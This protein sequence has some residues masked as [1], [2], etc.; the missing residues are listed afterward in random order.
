[1]RKLLCIPIITTA[2][3]VSGI[4]AYAQDPFGGDDDPFG[5]NPFGGGDA[6]AMDP[7]NPFGGGAASSDA[8]GVFGGAGT[9]A[10]DAAATQA[11]PLEVDPDPVVQ[12][13]RA[14]TPKSPAEMAKGLTWLL[15]IRRWDEIGRY[16]DQVAAENWSDQKTAEL[17]RAAG[18]S[19]WIRMRAR[20]SELTDTQKEFVGQIL[21]M[22]S[23]LARDPKWV[24]QWIDR[25]A[26]SDAGERRLAQLRLQDG[27]RLAIQR[28]VERLMSGDPKVLPVMLAGTCLV[29]GEPGI[30]ALRAAN[31]VSDGQRGARVTLA[32]ADLPGKHFTTE[33]AAGLNSSEIPSDDKSR[34][35]EKLVGKFGGLP[36]LDA[37]TK[38]LDREFD[39]R[40]VE[41]FESRARADELTDFVWRLTSD[42]N[43]IEAVD[44]PV[45][46]RSLERL[47][48]V[49]KLRNRQLTAEPLSA[50]NTVALLQHAYQVTPGLDVE[51]QNP[52]FEKLIAEEDRKSPSYWKSTFENA[53][54]WQMHGAAIR[55]LQLMI[56][57]VRADLV[58]MN[59]MSDLLK[60]PRPMVRYTALESIA[61][62]DP[63]IDYRGSERAI[64]TALEMMQL[65][66]GPHALVVGLRSDLRDAAKQQIEAAT[67]SNVTLANSAKSALAALDESNPIELIFLV[68]RVSDQS[69][70]ELIQRIRNTK[71]G[72]SIPIAVLTD[73]LYS[74]ERSLIERTGG[75]VTAVLS[76]NED[77]MQRVVSQLLKELDTEPM[78]ELD[79]A[80]F[81]VVASKFLTHISENHDRY[82]YYSLG[83]YREQLI[84]T[85]NN[86]ADAGRVRLLSGL[87]TRVSQ[88]ELAEIAGTPAVAAADRV[89]A[90]KAFG[91]S[92]QKFGNQLSKSEVEQCYELYNKLGPTDETIV[93]SMGYVLDVIE[94]RS[95]KRAWP[96]GL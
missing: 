37:I 73:E 7:G 53:T 60:D 38:H 91:S 57:N 94:A 44:A 42:G 66:N 29:F 59:F 30:D 84:S 88:F 32:L 74:H 96:Q 65:S 40:L 24:D 5:S 28:L 93:K 89:A 54:K 86:F 50:Q 90:A 56:A 48:Q 69:L 78:N 35:A 72:K 62:L 33:L 25:L 20:E 23:K 47:A 1:M 14:T 71:K 17:A 58:D 87:G 10:N 18:N 19:V 95:G 52:E 11:A 41:Y 79:R 26:N 36:S 39:N 63:L 77:N 85:S 21:R 9:N 92:I 43:S 49:A 70:F 46:H 61:K 51:S 2:V 34:L 13:L 64:Q 45:E 55:A 82:R 80:T 16:L 3:L 31:V 27:G 67:S 83:N 68:D 12:I 4:N 22:P 75:V 8:G 6:G 76:S 15:R 81:A